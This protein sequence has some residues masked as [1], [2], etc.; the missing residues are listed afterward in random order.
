[1]AKGFQL[2]PFCDSVI[3]NNGCTLVVQAEL[4]LAV[5]KYRTLMFFPKSTLI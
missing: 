3:L 5:F 4:F 1:M 2:K